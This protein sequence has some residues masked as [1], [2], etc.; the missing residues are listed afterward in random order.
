MALLDEFYK[1]DLKHNGDF[2]A[3]ASGDLDTVSR[4][5]NLRQAIFNRLV[6]ER[7]SLLHRPD[8]GIGIKRWQNDVLT[9]EVQRRLANEVAEQLERD[10]RIA[11]V[12]SVQV[13]NGENG[14]IEINLKITDNARRFIEERLEI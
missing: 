13:S 2:V 3:T 5:E 10:P 11:S 14:I 4:S 7:G 1:R 12:D 6:T 9:I 8:Y